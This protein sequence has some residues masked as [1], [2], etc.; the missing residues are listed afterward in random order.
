ML[1]VLLVTTDW[2]ELVQVPVDTW[3]LL[4]ESIIQLYQSLRTAAGEKINLKPELILV[5]IGKTS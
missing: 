3:R 4:M 2:P 5:R 1:Y